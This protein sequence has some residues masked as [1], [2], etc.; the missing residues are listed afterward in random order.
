MT[1]DSTQSMQRVRVGMTGLASILVLIGLMSA[2]LSWTSKEPPVKAGGAPQPEV[3]ANI[4]DGA[5]ANAFAPANEPLAELGVAPSTTNT[6]DEAE[7]A[8]R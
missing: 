1:S 5:S 2:V 6:S 7:P 3:V 4:T 8:A